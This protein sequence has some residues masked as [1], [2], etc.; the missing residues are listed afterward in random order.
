[1]FFSLLLVFHFHLG[2]DGKLQ[3]NGVIVTNSE[4]LSGHHEKI[5][6]RLTILKLES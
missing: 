3:G 2:A 4:K 5:I 6:P 1:M